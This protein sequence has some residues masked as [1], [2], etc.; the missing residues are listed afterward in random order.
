MD[1]HAWRPLIVMLVDRDGIAS[2]IAAAVRRAGHTVV[3]VT[4]L[5]TARQVAGA[6]APEL[7]LVR[8]RDSIADRRA[9][10]A[11]TRVAETA[12]A[13]LRFVRAPDG[14]LEALVLS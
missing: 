12:G 14:I 7:I 4:G 3:T 1:M 8:T 6:L 9:R 2:A 10:A 13:P 5:D 11:L